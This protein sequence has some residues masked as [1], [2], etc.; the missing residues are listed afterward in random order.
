MT[1][2]VL[3]GRHQSRAERY[4]GRSRFKNA[5]KSRQQLFLG[6][7]K[8]TVG[9]CIAANGDERRRTGYLAVGVRDPP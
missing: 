7:E 2:I 4:R 8:I 3:H 1:A 5:C 9:D 6:D